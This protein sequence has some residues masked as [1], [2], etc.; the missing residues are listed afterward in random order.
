M[1]NLGW[2]ADYPDPENF[3]DVLFRSGSLQN[4]TLFASPEVD[5][6]LAQARTEFD[7]AERARLYQEV[8]RILID[9]AVWI[10]LFHGRSNEVVKPYVQGY[11]PPRMVVPHL[12]YLTVSE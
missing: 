12:R 2:I 8:Q 7:S 5:A 9:E 3:L 4:H 1:F 6:L 10:P 11:I